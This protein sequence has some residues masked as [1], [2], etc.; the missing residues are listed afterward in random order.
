MI[1]W[2]F[3]G[4]TTLNGYPFTTNI[5]LCRNGYRFTVQFVTFGNTNLRMHNVNTCNHFCYCMFYLDTRVNF[6][7]IEVSI[8]GYQE[9]YCTSADIIHVFHNFHS[10][11]TNT[12]TQITRQGKCWCYFYYF[13]MTTLDGT[14]TFM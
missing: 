8:S 2:I 9:F 5:F 14:I 7:E 11:C 3:C 1:I 10:G 6:N 13:L 4:N 12:V